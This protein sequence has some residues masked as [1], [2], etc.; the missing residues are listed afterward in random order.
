[1]KKLTK[2]SADLGYIHACFQLVSINE[3]CCRVSL[4]LKFDINFHYA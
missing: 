4:N 3:L 1:M 2:F